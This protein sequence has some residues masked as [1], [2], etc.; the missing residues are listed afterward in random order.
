MANIERKFMLVGYCKLLNFS[1]SK[2]FESDTIQFLLIPEFPTNLPLNSLF[3]TNIF[4][5][6]FYANDQFAPL[7]IQ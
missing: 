6:L 7:K 1:L 3:A 5:E 2:I 4:L